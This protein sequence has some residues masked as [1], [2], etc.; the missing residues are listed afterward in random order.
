M[1]GAGQPHS[2]GEETSVFL[3][4]WSPGQWHWHPLGAPKKCR[5]PRSHPRYTESAALG[6]GPA[7]CFTRPLG[8]VRPISLENGGGGGAAEDISAVGRPGKRMDGLRVRVGVEATNRHYRL[9]AG[10]GK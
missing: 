8:R 7:V 1:E 10:A 2:L 4:V 5:F 6:W 3:K 9:L